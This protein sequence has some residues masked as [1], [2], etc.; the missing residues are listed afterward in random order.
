MRHPLLHC[1]E[2]ARAIE[3]GQLARVVL[4]MLALHA[5]PL[6]NEFGGDALASMQQQL[7][8]RSFAL[9]VLRARSNRLADLAPLATAT[10]A[11][12]ALARSGEVYVV[13]G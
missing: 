13:G 3:K 5:G 4:S 9:I 6:R 7:A 1:R 8:G 10:L 12:P 2:L 11:V